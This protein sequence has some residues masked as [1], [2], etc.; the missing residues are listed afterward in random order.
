MD[1][2]RLSTGVGAVFAGITGV[3]LV[4][5]EFR[6]RDRKSSVRDIRQ[7]NEEVE[8]LQHLYL[9][10]RRYVYR[11]VMYMIDQGMDP[12]LPPAPSFDPG[13]YDDDET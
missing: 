4:I 11:L 7:L 3:W 2:D 10:Q 1:V 5:R 8:A 12:P 6:R 13:E 9:E